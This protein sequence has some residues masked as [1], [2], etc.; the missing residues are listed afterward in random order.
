MAAILNLCHVTTENDYI[1]FL[2][3]WY[4]YFTYN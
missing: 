1:K 3:C 4:M 2:M